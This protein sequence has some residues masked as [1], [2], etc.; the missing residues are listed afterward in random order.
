MFMVKISSPDG[1]GP[2]L[3]AP[4]IVAAMDV[5]DQAAADAGLAALY[6]SSP[7]QGFLID[8]CLNARYEF[9]IEARKEVN[10]K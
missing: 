5:L 9:R 6:G 2:R 1:E 10:N 3:P 7:L 8:N 4:T